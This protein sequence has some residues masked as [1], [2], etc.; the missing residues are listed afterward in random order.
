MS[1]VYDIFSAADPSVF[2]GK[3]DTK[4]IKEGFNIYANNYRKI[5]KEAYVMSL[6]YSIQ[7]IVMKR[8]AYLIVR[9]KQ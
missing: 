8:H 9:I 6:R 2:F 3:G 4:W 7:L 1:A 5:L